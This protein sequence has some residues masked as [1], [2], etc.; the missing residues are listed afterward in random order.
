MT[1][2]EHTLV[3]IHAAIAVGA[4][5]YYGWTIVALAGVLSNLPDWDGLPMLVDMS[6]FESGHRVWGHNFIW[7]V[8]SS[9]FAAWTQFRCR[10]IESLGQRLTRFLPKEMTIEKSTVPVPLHI[11]FATGFCAQTLHL[12]CDMVVSGGNGLSDWQIKPFWPVFDAGYVFPL[13]PWGDVCPTVILMAGAIILLKL[14]TR[15]S[16][17]S[18]ATLICLCV[19][20]VVRGRMRGIL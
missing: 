17:V 3:G 19:Y 6:R 5:R 9:L 18:L 14:P 10:W 13:I 2:P 15:T 16:S 8:C 4:H 11:L 12:P 7:I 1:S 20:L